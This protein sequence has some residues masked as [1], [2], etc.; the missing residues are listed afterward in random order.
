MK[1]IKIN[2]T[3]NV[4]IILIL[5]AVL[6]ALVSLFVSQSLVNAM[7]NEEKTKMEI[8][9]D[10]MK[11]ISRAD[12]NS[13]LTLALEV[14]NGN[15]TIPVVVLDNNG[16]IQDY[17]NLDINKSDSIVSLHETVSEICAAGKNIRFN[18][19]ADADIENTRHYVDIY[20]DDSVLLRHL[21]LYPYI[22][23]SVVAIFVIIAGLL[24]S[25]IKKVEQNKLWVGLSKETAHQLGTPISSLL[26]WQEILEDKYPDDKTIVEMKKDVDSLRAVAERFSKIGSEPEAEICDITDIINNKADYISK[27]I[28]NKIKVV[29]ENP[30]HH[31]MGLVNKSLFEWVIEN[32][33]KNAA[34]AMA[35]TGTLTLRHGKGENKIWIEV[36][37]TGKGIPKSKFRKVFNPGYTTKKRGWGLGLSLSKRIISEYHNGKIYVKSS[38]LNKGTTFRIEIRDVKI[39]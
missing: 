5:A 33:C 15:H 36:S 12:E 10:A 30:P 21:T 4:K 39:A 11:S 17:R 25:N 2:I 29:C 26:A 23:M 6:I 24:L 1:S 3:D 35:G 28:S 19:D 27:R 18:L 31:V 37:D 34:D 20:Y 16:N 14:L 9:A 32:L 22:Q 13:D 38:E 7:K 8:W